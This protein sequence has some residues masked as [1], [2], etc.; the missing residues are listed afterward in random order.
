MI[1]L[2][3]GSLFTKDEKSEFLTKEQFLL[4]EARFGNFNPLFKFW[5]DKKELMLSR[6]DR[7]M[8]RVLA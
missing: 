5:N 1:V 6:S 8:E 2:P 4:K 7:K 3:K